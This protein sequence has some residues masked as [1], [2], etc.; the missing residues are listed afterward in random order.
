MVH[1]NFKKS[2]REAINAIQFLALEQNVRKQNVQNYKV[3]LN[4]V[5]V[6]CSWHKTKSHVCPNRHLFIKWLILGRMATKK[7]TKS[8]TGFGRNGVLDIGASK[9]VFMHF[10]FGLHCFGHFGFRTFCPSTIISHSKASE[11]FNATKDHVSR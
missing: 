9:H 5:P 8:E 10:V 3:Y 11:V 2:G 7:P 1:Q 6:L 4:G